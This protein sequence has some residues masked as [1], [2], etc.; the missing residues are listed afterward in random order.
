[1]KTQ[2]LRPGFMVALHSICK[3]GVQYESLPHDAEVVGDRLTQRLESLK[4]VEDIREHEEAVRIRGLAAYQ[5]RKFCGKTPFGL[6]CSEDNEAELDAGVVVAKG[7]TETFNA[8]S[9]FTKISLYVLKGRISTTDEQS[10]KAIAGEMRSLLNEV[11]EAIRD[12]DPVKIREAL[13]KVDQVNQLLVVEEQERVSVALEMARKAAREIKK[14]ISKQG[15]EYID[16]AVDYRLQLAALQEA[17][18]GFLDYED[19]VVIAPENEA[20][21]VQAGELDLSTGG[22]VEE[23]VYVS[24]APPQLDISSE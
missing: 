23:T 6:M 5:I 19:P 18:K 12:L 20:P 17:G 14:T 11:E 3:G 24:P 10:V 1:M 8:T 21:A 9:S 22:G 13:T 16:V 15:A 2:L 4:T 7:M